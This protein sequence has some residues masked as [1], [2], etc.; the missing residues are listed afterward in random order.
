MEA[1]LVAEKAKSAEATELSS[2][3]AELSIKFQE[4]L[5]V[6]LRSASL[7]TQTTT[8]VKLLDDFCHI[9]SPPLPSSMA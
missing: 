3:Y 1:C 7:L 2:K 9:R 4:K 5:K 8:D 6:C